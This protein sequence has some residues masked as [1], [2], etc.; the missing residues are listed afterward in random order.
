MVR[1]GC[2]DKVGLYDPLLMNLPDFDM[3]VRMC[4]FFDIHVMPEH[5]IGFRVLAHERNT[6]APS[7][8]N[9]AR[10]AW[11]T[12]HVLGHF[13][14]LP[15]AELGEIIAPWPQHEFSREPLVTLALAALRIGRPGYDQFGLGLLRECIARDRQ[16]FPVKEYFRLVG[17]HDPAGSRLAR[18][19][20]SARESPTRFSRVRSLLARLGTRRKPRE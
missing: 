12:T 11:E 7:A 3:W 1:R 19:D 2:Y 13:S 17:E 6:S 14:V 16:S 20:R 18:L 4:Q 10:A 8:P 15:E 9:L 5:L